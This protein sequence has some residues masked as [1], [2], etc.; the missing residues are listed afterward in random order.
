MKSITQDIRYRLSILSFT[1]KYGVTQAAI[2]YHMNR[3]F[4]YRLL[5][6]YDGTPNSL[7]PRSRKPHHH[8]N[9]H[10]PEELQLIRNM[11]RRN[12]HAGLVVL[13]VKLRLR[14]YRRSIT[15]L[16]RCLQ[17][18]GL[19]KIPLPNPKRISKQYQQALFPGEKVQ[20]D[21][22]VVPA[23]CIV[24]Q[25]KAN[26]ERMFQYTAIDE[27]TR[28]RYLEA[29]REQSTYSS[30]IFLQHLV[31]KF[32]FRIHKVQTDNGIEFTNRFVRTKQE[33]L[34]LFETQLA[35]YGIVHQKIRPY[36]PRH[37]G[38]VER[39]HRKDNDYFYAS[40]CFYSFED[41]KRQLT[42]R[43]RQYND[44]PMRPLKWKSPNE[45]LRSFLSTV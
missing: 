45:V 20:I 15:G 39:S 19:R 17:R 18:M 3:Q 11:W 2:K 7:M 34:T 44:F 14:G 16:Y 24:G 35:I 37:N 21:V 22:K 26:G 23:A 40:H 13:W 4:I 36:T 32:K 27:C 42:I 9:Q 1:E 41:F 28:V 8:P 43:N 5:W 33:R 38:K 12:S 29:F 6:R 25:A 31:K 10:T 30:T